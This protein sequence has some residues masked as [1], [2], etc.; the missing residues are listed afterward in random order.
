MKDV[1]LQGKTLYGK[2][3]NSKQQ[4]VILVVG[5]AC[6]SQ[7]TPVDPTGEC[8]PLLQGGSQL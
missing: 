2:G 8:L 1:S 4:S 3:G 6:Q 5:F 7:P